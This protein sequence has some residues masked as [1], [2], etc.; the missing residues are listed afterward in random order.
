M[1]VYVITKGSYSDYH[2]CAVATDKK[3][4]EKLKK[5]FTNYDEAHI[6]TYDTDAFIT[7][8]ERGYKLYICKKYNDE[9]IDI[10]E[11]TDFDYVSTLDFNVKKCKRHSIHDDKKYIIYIIYVWA[12]DENHAQKIAA[13]KI[14]EYRAKK[15]MI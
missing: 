14:A 3:K 2:I 4:A 1:K 11:I 8:I 10:D 9:Y 6:E 13:D 12:K 15:E 5:I 7:E